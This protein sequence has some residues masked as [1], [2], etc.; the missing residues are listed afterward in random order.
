MTLLPEGY[1]RSSLYVALEAIIRLS[2]TFG[3]ATVAEGTE[4]RLQAKRLAT[5]G[6]GLGQ[7]FLYSRPIPPADLMDLIELQNLRSARSA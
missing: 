3:P 2:D 7:G 1:L 4:E 5:L 6:C